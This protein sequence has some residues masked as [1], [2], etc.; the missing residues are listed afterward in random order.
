MFGYDGLDA[1]ATAE[2]DNPRQI[3]R[4]VVGEPVQGHDRFHAEK[5]NIDDV[6]QGPVVQV[7]QPAQDNLPGINAQQVAMLEVIVQHGR[8]Q[9]VGLGDGVGEWSLCPSAALSR[10]PKSGAAAA[11]Y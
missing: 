4:L 3:L 2:P 1:L 6:P 9:V 7:I 10:P 8:K 11:H 5:P